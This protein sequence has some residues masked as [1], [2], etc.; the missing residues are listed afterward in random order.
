[1]ISTDLQRVQ[2]QDI[3][4]YQLPAFVRDDFPLIGEFL[5]QYYISQEFPTAP[6]DIIQNI[7]EYLKLESLIDTQDETTLN[8]DI[9]FDDTEISAGTNL[10]LNEFGTYQ[11]PER[12]GLIKIDDEVILYTSKDRNSFNGCIRGFSG[13]TSFADDDGDLTFSSTEAT[14]HVQGSKIVNLSNIL[15][16]EFL[17]KLKQQIAPGFERREIKSEVNE[18]LF[19]SR[20]KDFY[21]SKGTDESFRILFAALYGEKAEVVKP[22]EFLFRPSDA[23]YRKTKDI[24]VEAVVGDP[25]KLKNQTLYQNAFP[26]YGIGEAFATILDAEKILRGDKT[27]YQ[28]SVDFDYSKDIDLTGGTLLGDFAAHPKTQNTVLVAS[29][30][31]VIDVDSTIGFPDRGQIQIDGKSGILTYRSKTINQFTEVGLLRE[32]K[33]EDGISYFDTN[34]THHHHFYDAATGELIDI[35]HEAISIN[36]LPSAP[37]GKDIERIDVVIRV[38]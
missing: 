21:S 12:Y 36:N 1:M 23:Q 33:L 14:S 8:A 18:K 2:I 25:L 24:V 3:A 22:K 6:A 38:S 26:E 5:K 13:V 28:L 31:S 15:L 32:V 17:I 11:F 29:G 27:Y 20:A 7:D 37:E 35:P 10:D 4:E 34:N 30:S 16:K 19:L 9:D